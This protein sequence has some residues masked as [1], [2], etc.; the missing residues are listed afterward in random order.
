MKNV[1]GTDDPWNVP[2]GTSISIFR[3]RRK[4]V[5]LAASTLLLSQ[6]RLLLDA[7]GCLTQ[8]TTLRL[9]M[10][11]R[12]GS[13]LRLDI[14]FAA[15]ATTAAANARCFPFLN[16]ASSSYLVSCVGGTCLHMYECC[17]Y[18]MDKEKKERK[19][20]SKI[21]RPFP[22]RGF[23]NLLSSSFLLDPLFL[24]QSLSPKGRPIYSLSWLMPIT[25]SHPLLTLLMYIL[26]SAVLLFIAHL[27][28]S[29]KL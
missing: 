20:G 13:V 23:I 9:K 8:L 22:H 14:V 26:Y 4:K 11:N 5:F 3:R 10:T 16:F 19:V 1:P 18:D 12:H 15:A 28:K 2:N 21:W 24:S 29:I 25:L 27:W 6:R 7:L 17:R